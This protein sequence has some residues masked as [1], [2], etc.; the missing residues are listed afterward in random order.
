VGSHP[1]T[2]SLTEWGPDCFGY[3]HDLSCRGTDSIVVLTPNGGELWSNGI[4]HISWKYTG[5]PGSTGENRI[6]SIRGQFCSKRSPQACPSEL[7][8]RTLRL[9]DSCFSGIQSVLRCTRHEQTTN[10]QSPTSVMIAFGWGGVGLNSPKNGDVLFLSN[11]AYLIVNYTWSVLGRI[12]SNLYKGGQ[13]LSSL[14]DNTV[15]RVFR[16]GWVARDF[17]TPMPQNLSPGTEL[18]H[19]D[20]AS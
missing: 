1:F 11:S 18:Q 3:G 8:A 19:K 5:K 15:E 14:G 9:A 17:V 4:Q 7:T 16:L 12:T 6:C 20:N 13:L 2:V 10:P